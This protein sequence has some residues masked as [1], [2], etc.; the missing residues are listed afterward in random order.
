MIAATLFWCGITSVFLVIS[1]GSILKHK[2][3]Q[4]RFVSTEGVVLASEVKRDAEDSDSG[5]T[6]SARIKYRYYVDGRNYISTRYAYGM[7][8]TS[9]SDHVQTVVSEHPPG[10]KVQVWYDPDDP[11][12][13]ILKLEVPGI[14]YFLLLF[15][16]P[17]VAVGLALIAYTIS[18]PFTYAKVRQFINEPTPIFGP[19]PGWGTAMQNVRGII[20]RPGRTR[21]RLLI[22]LGGGYALACFAGIFIVGF[23]LDGFGDPDPQMV[24]RTFYIAAAIGLA[25]ML[26][27][28]L[29][30]NRKATLEIDT[31]VGQLSL[32]SPT[33]DFRLGFTDIESWTIRAINDPKGMTVNNR[34]LTRPLLAIRTDE[35]EEVP[36]RVFGTAAH[37][38]LVARKVG[39]ALGELTGATLTESTSQGDPGPVQSPKTPGELLRLFARGKHTVEQYKD[40]M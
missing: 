40:I 32:T 36:I 35:G 34:V 27:S 23:L 7:G 19:I 39:E 3:A 17:F 10:K 13:A 22:A 20:I 33:R 12:E 38:P 1:L 2:D 18:V 31:S 5:P 26:L 28:L 11:G 24:F 4:R 15:L 16:Q 6:Y 14:L 8:S 25:A 9:E 30:R 29:P 37:A 21:L